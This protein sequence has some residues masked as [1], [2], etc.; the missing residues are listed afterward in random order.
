[1]FEE[2]NGQVM[3]I[4]THLHTHTHKNTHKPTLIQIPVSSLCLGEVVG[5]YGPGGFRREGVTGSRADPQS[6]P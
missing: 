3:L 1:M 5:A 4:L 2:S 6:G